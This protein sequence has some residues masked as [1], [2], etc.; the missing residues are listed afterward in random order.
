MLE[1]Y[2]LNQKCSSYKIRKIK[3]KIVKRKTKKLQKIT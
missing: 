2:N 1:L 3:H